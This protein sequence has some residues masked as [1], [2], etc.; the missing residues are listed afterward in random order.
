VLSRHAAAWVAAQVGTATIS[1]DPA[2]CQALKSRG[3]PDGQ[4]REL[5][6]GTTDP[7]GSAVIVATPVLRS[8]VGSRLS[9][10]YA[11]GL[12][13]R[14]GSGSQQVQVRAIA[15]HGAAAYMSM[16]KADLAARRMSGTQLAQ[17]PR[18]LIPA[19]ARGQLAGGEVD[20]RLMTVLTGLAANYPVHIVAFGDSGPVTDVAPFRSAELA[21]SNLKAMRAILRVQQSPFRVAH[22]TFLRLRAGQTV[23]RI[24]FTAPST[25]GLLGSGNTG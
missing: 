1:C 14:F 22:A 18:I 8:Q 15:P 11:P 3:M 16:A 4:L 17:S 25:F 9:S 6:R 23:L 5:R 19:A 10:V 21:G 20:S 12:L 7:L 13:A 2:M 24:D